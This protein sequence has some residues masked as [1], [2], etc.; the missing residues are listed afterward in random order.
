MPV[1]IV[2]FGSALGSPNCGALLARLDKQAGGA[3]LSSGTAILASAWLLA[4]LA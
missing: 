3:L 2:A 1:L 4:Q